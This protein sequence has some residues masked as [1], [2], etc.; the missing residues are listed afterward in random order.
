MTKIHVNQHV[1]R[2]NKKKGES[3]PVITV[4]SKGA[5]VYA[6]KVAI[7]GPSV[8][9]YSPDKPLSC[10]A[11]VWVE[12]DS[13]VVVIKERNGNDEPGC[14]QVGSGC[15]RKVTLGAGKDNNSGKGGRRVKS[16]GRGTNDRDFTKV[17][18]KKFKEEGA[19]QCG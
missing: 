12:T 1:I 8:V 5:N 11:T 14:S 15:D 9:V 7:L 16:K 4:K 13:K 2:S 17:K 19:Q 10:G 6:K 18:A 3:K